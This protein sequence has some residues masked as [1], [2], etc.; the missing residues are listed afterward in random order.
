M[1][2]L[3]AVKVFEA[4]E[5]EKP[6]A[7]HEQH[8]QQTLTGLDYFK[9]DKVQQDIAS[10]AVNKQQL[11]NVENKAVSNLQFITKQAPTE[12]KRNALQRFIKA[13]KDGKFASK[14]M[15]KEV[16][17]FYATNGKL[18]TG[19]HLAFLDKLFAQILDR[20]VISMDET[21]SADGVEKKPA[22]R[23]IINPKIVLTVSFT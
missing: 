2:F 6:V 10:Q 17:D 21:T 15:P 5:N 13:I 23:A 19:D 8:H 20:Y 11:S 16:N 12:Q 1:T 14:G 7:L 22:Q 3:Q 18:L 9:T 4:A